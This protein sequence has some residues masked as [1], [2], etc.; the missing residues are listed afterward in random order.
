MNWLAVGALEALFWV[1]LGVAVLAR[2]WWRRP[3]LARWALAWLVADTVGF[4]VLGLVELLRTGR[5]STLQVV[6]M[7]AV[8]YAASA[9]RRELRR[10][11]RRTRALVDAYRA[12]LSGGRPGSVV[13][14][15]TFAVRRRAAG[16][17]GPT[18]GPGAGEPTGT[19]DRRPPD[20]EHA[21]RQRTWWLRHML[22]FALGQLVLWSVILL[23]GG[24]DDARTAFTLV[25][26]W[27]AVFVVDTIWSLSYSVVPRRVR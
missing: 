11:D 14:L 15:A 1:G 6:V 9:G 21:R 10:F 4:L 13:G 24:P 3:R 22:V 23:R 20:R 26:I 12:S 16:R 25:R 27:A 2:Y 17:T 19:G 18:G 5:I 8:G 7:V